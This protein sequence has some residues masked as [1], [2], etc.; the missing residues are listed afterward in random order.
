VKTR[1]F[2]LLMVY[3][4]LMT[5]VAG[6]ASF[7]VGLWTDNV[8]ATVLSMAIVTGLGMFLILRWWL[9]IARKAGITTKFEWTPSRVTFAIT[10][11][12]AILLATAVNYANYAFTKSRISEF[13]VSLIVL[14]PILAFLAWKTS[15]LANTPKPQEASMLRFS[16]YMQFALAMLF[17][18]NLALQL[19]PW[20]HAYD[21]GTGE[22]LIIAGYIVLIPL[23]PI[24][25][26]YIR[27]RYLQARDSA[28]PLPA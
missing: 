28:T 21:L 19:R 24:N 14:F 22:N 2:V 10:Y 20:H 26:Y 3:I 8:A 4:L 23:F 1:D 13:A 16:F 12:A 11:I 27:K 9:R 6:G 7:L 15:L 17:S 18:L 5:I 25:A